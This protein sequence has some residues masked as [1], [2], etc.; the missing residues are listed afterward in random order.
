VLHAATVD[1]GIPPMRLVVV[2]MEI[3]A[4]I[5]A[6]EMLGIAGFFPKLDLLP[7]SR[8]HHPFRLAGRPAAARLHRVLAGNPSPSAFSSRVARG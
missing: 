2:L 7:L 3:A 4:G 5:F 1:T 8:R 6:M